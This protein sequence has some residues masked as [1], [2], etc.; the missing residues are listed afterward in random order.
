MRGTA[1]RVLKGH[2]IWRFIPAHAG[3]GAVMAAA[4]AMATVHPR[5]CGERKLTGGLIEVNT[6]SSPRMQGTAAAPNV[7]NLN[8]RFIPAHAGNGV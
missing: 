6:G 7:F 1:R 3:N 8:S 2:Q 5:A 4:I